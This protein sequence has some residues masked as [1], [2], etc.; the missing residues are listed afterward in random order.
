MVQLKSKEGNIMDNN[1]YL[2]ITYDDGTT[3]YCEILCIFVVAGKN[4]A[5]VAPLDENMLEKKDMGIPFYRVE[6][7]TDEEG[8]EGI[9][10][11]LL[12]SDM[13]IEAVRAVFDSL[14]TEVTVEEGGEAVEDEDIAAAEIMVDSQENQQKAILTEH[15]KFVLQILIGTILRN[16]ED[17]NENCQM[18]DV[19]IEKDMRE[20][21]K[22]IY[23]KVAR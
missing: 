1:E 18:A 6:A 5:A 11:E 16:T 8:N 22:D 14:V 21:L 19:A 17:E 20:I 15:E 2:K 23:A 9:L 12:K 13:E 4:Y 10:L 3:G 7:G